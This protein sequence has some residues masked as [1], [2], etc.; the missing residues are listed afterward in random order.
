MRARNFFVVAPLT[1][2]HNAWVAATVLHEV[3]ACLEVFVTV[4]REVATC[5]E[6]AIFQHKLQLQL[7]ELEELRIILVLQDALILLLL[8]RRS[9]R[10]LEEDDAFFKFCFPFAAWTLTQKICPTLFSWIRFIEIMLPMP[11]VNG[12]VLAKSCH[13]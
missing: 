6:A 9:A 5:L 3:A 7:E 4:L 13:W 10:E 8:G 1:E 12:A 2:A 11:V